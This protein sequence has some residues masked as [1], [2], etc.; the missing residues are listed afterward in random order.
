M[1]GIT[2]RRSVLSLTL[3][4]NGIL[5]RA[6]RHLDPR[7]KCTNEREKFYFIRLS[8][9]FCWSNFTLLHEF[10]WKIPKNV[11]QIK[12]FDEIKLSITSKSKLHLWFCIF[13]ERYN[14]Y[15]FSRVLLQLCSKNG[16]KFLWNLSISHKIWGN[17]VFWLVEIAFHLTFEWN[18]A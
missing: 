2:V 1:G 18:L 3:H 5:S 17:G 12:K 8:N 15:I 6:I 13:H 9:N 4:W 14:P 11:G 10:V 16:K 7:C